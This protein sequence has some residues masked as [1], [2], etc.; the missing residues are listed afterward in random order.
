M[1]R[2]DGPNHVSNLFDGG[3]PAT[4]GD[5]TEVTADWLN[6]VQENLCAFIEAMGLTLTKNDYDQLTNAVKAFGSQFGLAADG[7]GR[8]ATDQAALDAL[9]KPGLFY[10]NAGP[11]GGRALG[12]HLS[13]ADTT[14]RVQIALEFGS[15]ELYARTYTDPTWTTW[16][17]LRNGVWASVWTGSLGSVPMSSLSSGGEGR[18]LV[19]CDG[20]S[21]LIEIPDYSGLS[22]T[23]K[24]VGTTFTDTGGLPAGDAAMRSLYFDISSET[25]FMWKLTFDNTAG[26]WSSAAVTITE[27]FK[28]Q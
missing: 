24:V 20:D 15:K 18:Y 23:G 11:G 28:L 27:I 8:L 1:H 12:I 16:R 19:T 21:Y 7:I 4:Q 13:S 17:L 14:E 22:M 25:F 26:T 3:D 2:I 9:T 10:T 5:G 6:D